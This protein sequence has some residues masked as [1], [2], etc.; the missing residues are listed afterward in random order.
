MDCCW[1]VPFDGSDLLMGLLAGPTTTT[2]TRHPP[3]APGLAVIEWL[4]H[5]NS[6]VDAALHLSLPAAV[7]G[8]LTAKER[9]SI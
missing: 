3:P 2:A 9:C 6:T 8:L 5:Y 1:L 4:A 7:R